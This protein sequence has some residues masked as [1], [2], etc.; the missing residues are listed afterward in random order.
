MADQKVSKLKSDLKLWTPARIDLKRAGAAI[1][2]S[3]NLKFQL[4]HAKARD[5]VRLNWD[6][7]QTRQALEMT[8][9]PVHC[10][11]SKAKSRDEFLLRPDFGRTL[12]EESK[13]FLKSLNT[14]EVVDVCFSVSDGLSAAAIDT[15]LIPFWQALTQELAKNQIS[16]G[17]V[18][19]A[20]FGRVAVSDPIGE[21][22]NAKVSVILIGERPGLSAADSLG[23]YL[24]Y[25]PQAGN[26][27]A[28]RNCISNIHP[29]DGLGYEEAAYKICYLIK[30]SIQR[31]YSGVNL[32]DNSDLETRE[33]REI[34]SAN[35]KKIT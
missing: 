17:P 4:A 23:I 26:T 7:Q 22:L 9:V 28:N 1:A 3:E 30:E 16:F 34:V 14:K 6:F 8:G 27:D 35:F 5:A 20:P 2:T 11:R 10:V 18:I 24:T 15:H 33:A 31:G 19:L 32:K 25:Q 29:P 12:S 21:A 13:N